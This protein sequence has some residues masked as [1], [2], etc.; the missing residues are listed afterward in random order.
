MNALESAQALLAG[1][2]PAGTVWL[3]STVVVAALMRAMTGWAFSLTAVPM[4]ALVLPPTQAMLL[5][6]LLAIVTT[7]RSLPSDRHHLSRQVFVP[8]LTTG[9]AGAVLGV[10]LHGLIGDAV[11]RVTTGALVLALSAAMALVRPR[12][13]PLDRPTL[14]AAG[15]ASGVMGGAVGIAGPPVV[16]LFFMRARRIDEVRATLGLGLFVNSAMAAVA[17]GVKGAIDSTTLLLTALAVPLLLAGERLGR[18]LL[19]RQGAHAARRV[20]VAL[21]VTVG[22]VCFGR[23]LLAL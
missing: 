22:L 1:I 9:L 15:L 11:L 21:T 5:N 6:I 2:G 10:W 7:G 14:A 20:S 13:A 3:G 8:L 18:Q 16:L 4:L 23:G 19:A 17:F 12:P